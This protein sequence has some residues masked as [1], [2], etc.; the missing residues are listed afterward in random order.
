MLSY[1]DLGMAVEADTKTED[2]TFTKILFYY[3]FFK[4]FRTQTLQSPPPM[5]EPPELSATG[6]CGQ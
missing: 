1:T 2:G 5:K 3:I 6:A 4:L